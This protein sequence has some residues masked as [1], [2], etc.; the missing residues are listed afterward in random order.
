MT[1]LT[2]N[3]VTARKPHSCDQCR[4]QIDTGDRYLYATGVWDGF[5]VYHAHLSCDYAARALHELSRLYPHETINLMNDLSHHD[6]EWL[7]KRHPAVAMRF[8]VVP[9]PYC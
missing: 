3:I 4:Q 1:T 7:A 8:G 6:Y 9:T 2:F 5:Q